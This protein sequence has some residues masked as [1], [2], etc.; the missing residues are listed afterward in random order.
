MIVV[1]RCCCCNIYSTEYYSFIRRQ[2]YIQYKSGYFLFV[3]LPTAH[4]TTNESTDVNEK[5]KRI[6]EWSNWDFVFSLCVSLSLVDRPHTHKTTKS[7]ITYD[8]IFYIINI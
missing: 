2:Q 5:Q 7:R 1:C 8:K 6:D 3:S 4:T